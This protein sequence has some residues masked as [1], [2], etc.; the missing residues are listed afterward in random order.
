V[1]KAGEAFTPHALLAQVRTA[2]D[3]VYDLTAGRTA[4]VLLEHR[5]EVGG[6]VAA[7]ALAATVRTATDAERFQLIK[8]HHL[9]VAGRWMLLP[10]RR[11]LAEW[12][13]N[14]EY[15]KLRTVASAA[16]V[17]E[18]RPGPDGGGARRGTVVLAPDQQLALITWDPEGNFAVW[19]VA[20]G[21]LTAKFSGGHRPHLVLVSEARWR[22]VTT[23]DSATSTGRYRRDV[24]TVWDLSTG[25]RIDKYVGEDLHRRF[26]GYAE[27]SVGD[28]F[29]TEAHSPDGRLRATAHD[30]A[31]SVRDVEQD[32][33]VLR[34][35]HA[36]TRQ[37][38]VAFSHDGQHLLARWDDDEG[39]A[40]EIFEVLG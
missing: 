2:E 40:V 23:A 18:L 12:P 13:G 3:R 9:H 33:E 6:T 28:A 17:N 22:L 39:S 27:H 26:T 4:G 20:S 1:V 16:L 30:G 24:A 36:G 11:R 35:D 15:V 19:D 7:G 5:I 8:R 32:S 14:A 38:R 10:D 31:V 25:T 37:A 29:V 21:Q 34:A